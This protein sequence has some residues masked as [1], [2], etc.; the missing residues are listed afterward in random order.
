M[1]SNLRN[2]GQISD[3]ASLLRTQAENDE[4]QVASSF[5]LLHGMI[6]AVPVPGFIGTVQ[7]LSR[8]IG[9]FGQTLEASGDLGAIKTSLQNVTGGLATGFEITLIALVFALILQLWITFQQGRETAFLD[10]CNDYCHAHVVS[11]LRLLRRDP[12][13]AVP[14]GIE[15]PARPEPDGVQ[16][17][18]LPSTAPTGVVLTK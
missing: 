10:E 3:V 16:P 17:P 15:M 4:D 13:S 8:A 11:K 18:L 5:G 9:S 1:L 14:A 7:G 2:F 12:F 6:W